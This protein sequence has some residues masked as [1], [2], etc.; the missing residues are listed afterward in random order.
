MAIHEIYKIASLFQ[1]IMH[2]AENLSFFCCQINFLC[3]KLFCF[4]LNALNFEFLFNFAIF[5]TENRLEK[6][7]LSQNIK[8]LFFFFSSHPLS[9]LYR[10]EWLQASKKTREKINL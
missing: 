3:E 4:H 10:Q 2:V 8:K 6:Y 9:E 5:V 7:S 1:L